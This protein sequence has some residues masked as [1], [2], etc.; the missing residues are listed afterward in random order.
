MSI[1]RRQLN[2]T[3]LPDGKVLVTGGSSAKGFDNPAGA[4]HYA[5]MWDPVTETW[6]RMASYNT[7]RGYHSIALLLPDGRVLSSGGD[8]ES[9]AEIYSPPYLFKGARPVITS[10]PSK[11]SYGETFLVG[12][13]D[14]A[15]IA[16]VSW[17]RLSSVTHAFNQ[18][19]RINFLRFVSAEGALSITAPSDPNLC[20]PGHY[21][22]FLLNG[23]G[24]PSKAK[25]IQIKP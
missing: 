10:G 9:N 20:P 22:L 12:N 1:A 18:N 17:L 24:V 13:A 15:S 8:Y 25:M 19:Q 2:A 11:V 4:V 3:L 21:M 5:E 16:K 7:Y 23:N 14:A 6:S